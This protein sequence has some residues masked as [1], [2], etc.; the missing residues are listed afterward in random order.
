MT[1]HPPPLPPRGFPSSPILTRIMSLCAR[2]VANPSTLDYV[3]IDKGLWGM[4]KPMLEEFYK[5][6][7]FIVIEYG[8]DGGYVGCLKG[9]T[10][11][12]S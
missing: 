10:V 3:V 12:L 4:L 5:I 11:M 7:I 2:G 9:F 8:L 1:P 6:L